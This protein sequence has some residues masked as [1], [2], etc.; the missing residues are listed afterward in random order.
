MSTQTG[1]LNSALELNRRPQDVSSKKKY[2]SLAVMLILGVLSANSAADVVA[3]DMVGNASQNLNSFVNPWNSAFVSGGDGFQKYQRGVSPSIPFSVMDDSLVI[4]PAD[5]L[6]I[7]KDGNTDVFFGVVDTENPQNS[8][9]V[10]ATWEF[11]VSGATGLV[12]SIDMGAMGDFE[13]S[14]SFEWTY[15][16]DGGP[17]LTAFASTVDEAGSFSYTLE[18]GASFLLNDPMLMQG[19]ILSDDLASFSTSLVGTGATLTLTLTATFNGGTEAVAFQNIVIEEGGLPTSA[20]AYDMVASASQNLNSFTN[21]W[22]SAFVSAGD[23]FQKYQRGVSSSIPFSVLD[24]SLVIFPTDSLGIIKD[25][26]LDEFFGVVDTENPQNSGPVSATWDFDISGTTG[27]ML[28]IDMGAMGDFESSDSF[29]WTYSIDGGPQLTAFASTVDEAGSFSYTLE[30]GASFTLNDPMLMQGTILSNDLAS[31]STPLVGTGATLTLTLTATFNGGTEA[32]AFQS[33]ILSEADVPPPP[34]SELEIFEIQGNGIA[35]PVDGNVV[36]T[37]DNV[38]TALAPNGFFMQTPTARTDGDVDTSDGIFVFTGAATG[39][40]VGDNVDVTGQ[41]DEFFGFTEL[42]SATVTPDGTGLVPAAVEFGTIVPSP[43]PTAPSCSIEFECYEGMLIE[44]PDGTVTGP[45]QRFSTD[46]IAEVHITAAPART[47]REPGIEFPGTPPFPEWDG[48]PEVFELD[49]DKLGLPNQIIPAGSSFSATG[50]L[51]FEFG[52]YELWPNELAFDP[53]PLPLPVRP[54]DAGEFTVGTL[55]LFRLFDDVDD[56]ADGDR[57]DFVVSTAEY[58]RRLAKLSAYIREVLDA[59]DILAVQEVES[60]KVLGDLAAQI[61]SD[62]ASVIYVAHLQEGNDIGTIDVGFLTRERIQVDAITQVDPGVT[63]ENP[64]TLQQDILHDRPPLL[65]EGSCQVEFGTFPISV[66]AVHNRSLSGIDGSQGL[67]VRAKRL[68][69]AESIATKVQDLQLADPDTRLI[70]IGDFNAF[71]FTDGYV[72]AL[73]VISGDFDPAASL[74][75]TEEDCSG[76]VNPDLDSPLMSA[77]VEERY[78]FIFRGSAQ[79]LDHALSTQRLAEEISGPE[80]GRGNADAAVDLIN[81]NTPANLPLRSSDHDG[82]VV[83]INKDE[84]AD[85]VPNDDDICPATA[86]P[87]GV[88]TIGLKP[89][90]YALTGLL[91]NTFE[92]SHKTVFTT[93][94]TGGCSCE[95]IITEL[96]LGFGHTRFGCSR[97]VMLQWSNRVN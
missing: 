60:L 88:P 97:G 63:F 85:G 87:E 2:Q 45:N 31:F 89:N 4:F 79:V 65:L 66:M 32:V 6:G 57:D 29:E 9:P 39:L 35:S 21:P 80:F 62:D 38:V 59:P 27:L 72:D 84:D 68:L 8:G 49:P 33:I 71:E 37:L 47:F 19:T 30:G 43:D 67:R 40:A 53:A 75:C 52:G 93:G 55:N 51:G 18:G 83:Y 5:N 77:S 23:G 24:D 20:T 90:H 92:S 61:E 86:I 28:S 73:G 15:S 22:N 78:S 11:D 94:D 46:P 64:I 70:V 74:V 25:G 54:R 13:S 42:T 81:D 91:G 36:T 17:E 69:Q 48:N 96:G 26:N 41:V 12:L 76:L 16:I 7:I 34:P 50:V 95:Q 82:L 14:D 58:E 44:I 56:P 3:F 1:P 10:S